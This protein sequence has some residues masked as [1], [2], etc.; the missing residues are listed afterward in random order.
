MNNTR[1]DFLKTFVATS[2]TL[3]LVSATNASAN[4]EKN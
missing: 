2:V 1:R 3:P 4:T